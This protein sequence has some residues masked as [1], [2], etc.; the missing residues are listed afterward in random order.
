MSVVFGWWVGGPC[1]RVFD[2]GR[3]LALCGT[4]ARALAFVAAREDGS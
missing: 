4:E 3:L 2:G 1:W